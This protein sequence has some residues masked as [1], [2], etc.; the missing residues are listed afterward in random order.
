MKGFLINRG[1]DSPLLI[2]HESYLNF[3]LNIN[4]PLSSGMMH[5]IKKIFIFNTIEFI[6]IDDEKKYDKIRTL[7]KANNELVKSMWGVFKNEEN[8]Q[9]RIDKIT[10]VSEI[11]SRF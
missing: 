2:F 7:L 4:K 5:F 1:D 10:E 6:Y 11:I 9:K 3:L 8:E